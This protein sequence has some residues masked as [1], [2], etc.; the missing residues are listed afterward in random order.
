MTRCR[1]L[2]DYMSPLGLLVESLDHHSFRVYRKDNPSIEIGT[3]TFTFRGISVYYSPRE[4]VNY[5]W[6]R[7]GED[8]HTLVRWES[9]DWPRLVAIALQ[10]PISD[11]DILGL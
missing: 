8:R 9:P 2:L 5:G 3:G 1:E 7:T 6:K 10:T 4:K 11:E